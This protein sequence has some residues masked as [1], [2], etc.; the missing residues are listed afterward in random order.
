MS[1]IQ[2]DHPESG[3]VE[4]VSSRRGISDITTV[5]TYFRDHGARRASYISYGGRG[6][7]IDEVEIE[8][9][10]VV[11]TYDPITRR[12]S[13]LALLPGD[14]GGFS[15]GTGDSIPDFW[16]FPASPESV[17]APRTIVEIE[18]RTI[19]GKVGTGKSVEWSNVRSSWWSWKGIELRFEVEV[20]GVV[21][22]VREVTRIETDVPIP[23][24]VFAIPVDVHIDGA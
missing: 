19:A 6:E 16:I 14:C 12:G 2:T 10:R 1:S 17:N 11:T 9:D 23:D 3:I 21:Q 15:L 18:N 4:T 8:I 22:S 24:Q 13:R 20:G 7:D 5:V